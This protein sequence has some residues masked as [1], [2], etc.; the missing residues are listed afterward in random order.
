MPGMS[1]YSRLLGL[2]VL[3]IWGAA[4]SDDG[5]LNAP[6]LCQA[7]LTALTPWWSYSGDYMHAC[8][9]C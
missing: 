3:G 4:C 5:L 2:M 8:T 7:P 1:P 9:A 6:A